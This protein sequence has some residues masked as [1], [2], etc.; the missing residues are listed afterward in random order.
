MIKIALA[1]IILSLAVFPSP[2][3]TSL[4]DIPDDLHNEYTCMSLALHYEAR[5][6]GTK[7]M[8]AV[9]N[10]ILNRVNHSQFPDTICE[11]VKQ[12]HKKTCQFSWVC[13]P[14]TT[15]KEPNISFSARLIAY[16]A[17]INR[18]LRDVTNGALFFHTTA[19]SPVWSATKRMTARIGNHLFYK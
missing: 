9:A 19:I 4:L 14:T 16:E 13:N 17:V 3:K 10:V 6:E 2:V 12:R 1:A 8:I 7:G 5:G 18:S 11:V 15:R